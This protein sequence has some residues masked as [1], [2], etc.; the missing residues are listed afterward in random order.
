MCLYLK[1]WHN[2]LFCVFFRS[3]ASHSTNKKTKLRAES[4]KT[5]GMVVT[6]LWLFCKVLLAFYLLPCSLSLAHKM[7]TARKEPSPAKEDGEQR[8][9]IV[10]AGVSCRLPESDNVE[11]FWQHLIR[12]EDMVTEDGRRWPPG[13][14]GLPKRNGKLNVT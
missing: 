7:E 13:M 14:Y 2:C 12:G 9:D 1:L 8:I 6:S 11:E 5:S 10:I 3:Q 4:S